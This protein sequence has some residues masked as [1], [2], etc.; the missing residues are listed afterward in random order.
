[1]NRVAVDIGGTFTDIVVEDIKNKMEQ[2]SKYDGAT[3]IACKCAH[4]MGL[5]RF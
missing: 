5:F 2:L 4:D 1:M 3:S